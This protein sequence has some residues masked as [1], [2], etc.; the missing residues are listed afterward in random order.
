M[1]Q[2]PVTEFCMGFSRMAFYRRAALINNLCPY[3]ECNI[4][5]TLFFFEPECRWLHILGT[6]LLRTCVLESFIHTCQCDKHNFCNCIFLNPPNQPTCRGY[7]FRRRF[8][9]HLLLLMCHL[10]QSL[11]YNLWY[12]KTIMKQMDAHIW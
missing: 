12:V 4:I 1:M 6:K 2:L 3:N 7:F 11:P 5:C 8:C 10:R 9:T